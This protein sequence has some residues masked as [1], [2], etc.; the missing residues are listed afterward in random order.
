MRKRGCRCSAPWADDSSDDN[1]DDS[2][3]SRHHHLHADR[4]RIVPGRTIGLCLRIRGS[5]FIRSVSATP[6]VARALNPQDES[7][8]SSSTST[9]VWLLT[10]PQPEKWEVL[11]S[12]PTPTLPLTRCVTS[13]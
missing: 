9:T 11:R 4:T 3:A 2:R 10:S 7:S 13:L 8:S 5:V 12:D 1:D 6:V